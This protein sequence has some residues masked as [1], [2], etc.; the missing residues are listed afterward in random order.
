M[1]EPRISLITLGVRDLDR[2]RAFYAA[3][4][5][6]E[7]AA[8]DGVAF[9]QLGPLALSLYVWDDFARDAGVAGAAAGFRGIALAYN[10]RTKEEVDARLTEA[11]A[12]GAVIVKSAHDVFWGG[13]IAYFAD[14][15]GH[16]WEIAWNPGFPIAEDGAITIKL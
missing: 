13:R 10:V 4:G 8:A 14:P 11:A 12:A 7:A 1:F 2:A 16:L 5:W 3:L 6:R 15:D 9:F